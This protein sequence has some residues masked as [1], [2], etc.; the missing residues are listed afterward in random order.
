MQDPG[1]KILLY[2]RGM[3]LAQLA[4][5]LHVNPG[6]V[7]RWAQRKTP[8][9]RALEIEKATSGQISRSDLRPD[10][11]PVSENAA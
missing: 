3:S 8:P 6:T 11:W 9:V 5:L 10:I 2:R 7:T 1:L 4:S